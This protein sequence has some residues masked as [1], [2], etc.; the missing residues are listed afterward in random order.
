MK[1]VAILLLGIFFFGVTAL[2]FEPQSSILVL[3]EDYVF[4]DILA[5]GLII[6]NPPYQ[7]LVWWTAYHQ[8]EKD[9][10]NL[11]FNFALDPMQQVELDDFCLHQQLDW[12]H[13]TCL[14]GEEY[15]TVLIFASGLDPETQLF[16]QLSQLADT[17]FVYELEINY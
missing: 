9:K 14:L 7:D 11:V 8:D 3:P 10:I 1:V 12:H 17:S 16:D 13:Y 6:T 4:G 2:A 15:C 5:T